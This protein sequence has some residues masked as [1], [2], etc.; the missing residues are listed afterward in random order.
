MI[1]ESAERSEL[2]HHSWCSRDWPR[3]AL[4]TDRRFPSARLSCNA[5]ERGSA[6]LLR[7]AKKPQQPADESERTA[8]RDCRPCRHAE[9]MGL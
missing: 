1:V 6:E 8:K 3:M 4:G 5:C 7:P 9:T 2:D